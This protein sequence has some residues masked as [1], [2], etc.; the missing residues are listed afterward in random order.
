MQIYEP[1]GQHICGLHG[2]IQSPL[3]SKAGNY[4]THRDPETVKAYARVDDLSALGKFG[5]PV[6][7]EIDHEDRVIIAESKHRI[8][9]YT[10]DRTYAEAEAQPP[11][12]PVAGC[13]PRPAVGPAQKIFPPSRTGR[14]PAGRPDG[15][16]AVCYTGERNDAV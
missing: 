14:R 8:Q 13:G 10:K 3:D 15:L 2:D 12:D 7:I 6:A 16:P 5:R 1:D 9:V 4:V 11:V